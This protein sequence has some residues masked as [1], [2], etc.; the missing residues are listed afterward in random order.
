MAP[1]ASFRPYQTAL[2]RS[3]GALSLQAVAQRRSRASGLTRPL[4]EAI[5]GVLFPGFISS[6]DGFD[7]GFLIRRLI[8]R[9]SRPTTCLNYYLSSICMVYL[10]ARTFGGGA[11][12]S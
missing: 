12:T 2:S 9:A 8:H 5:S 3:R 10:L 11:C 6:K 1:F 7:F 4:A